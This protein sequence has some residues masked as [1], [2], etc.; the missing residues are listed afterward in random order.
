MNF[1]VK[2]QN[3]IKFPVVF[4][5]IT[6]LVFG[7]FCIGMFHEPAE[8]MENMNVAGVTAIQGK[9][10]CCGVSVSQHMQSWAN[11]FLTIPREARD[12][13]TLFALGLLLAFVVIRNIFAQKPPND[14]AFSY[15]QYLRHHPNLFALQPLRLAFARG[16][17]N[18]KVF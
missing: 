1:R 7:F 10:G 18:T 15:R 16:I 5:T 12:L 6:T 9:Q 17:L 14:F 2:I 13:L 8:K 3:I 4:L 11:T